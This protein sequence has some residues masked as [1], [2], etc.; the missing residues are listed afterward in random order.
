M[1]L[2]RRGDPRHGERGVQY[3]GRFINR[4]LVTLF[5]N[6]TRDAIQS[7]RLTKDYKDLFASL[8]MAPGVDLEQEAQASV[9]DEGTV[10]EPNNS[11][12]L[13]EDEQLLRPDSVDLSFPTAENLDGVTDPVR[14]FLGTYFHQ[15]ES[16]QD[17]D[18][19]LMDVVFAPSAG[20]SSDT[21]FDAVGEWL[22]VVAP[23]GRVDEPSVQRRGNGRRHKAQWRAAR[24]PLQGGTEYVPPK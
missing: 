8:N 4:H 10:D 1:R 3:T 20:N 23:S 9:S 2:D 19:R 7:K 14:D 21:V 17:C 24:V 5:P 11:C 6:R 18:R 12:V 13:I 22:S 15:W 16:C